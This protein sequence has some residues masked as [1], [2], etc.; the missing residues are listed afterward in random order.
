M[1]RT[2]HTTDGR[3][4]NLI[5]RISYGGRF[6]CVSGGKMNRCSKDVKQQSEELVEKLFFWR[7]ELYFPSSFFCYFPRSIWL[8]KNARIYTCGGHWGEIIKS[9]SGPV[10]KTRLYSIPR[11]IIWSTTPTASHYHFYTFNGIIHPSRFESFWVSW[12][13][14]SPIIVKCP[15]THRVPIRILYE[16][17]CIPQYVVLPIVGVLFCWLLINVPEHRNKHYISD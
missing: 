4:Y 2:R 11:N 12:L 15:T 7:R 3:I 13:F 16:S 6:S 10:A 17:S 1:R 9:D 8:P 5:K 14:N